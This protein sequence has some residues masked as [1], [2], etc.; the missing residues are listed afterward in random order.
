MPLPGLHERYWE[1]AV[2]GKAKWGLSL[3]MPN[4]FDYEQGIS[5][6]EHKYPSLYGVSLPR[7]CR[8]LWA[9]ARDGDVC[10]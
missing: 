3:G 9:C 8:T 1:T 10:E 4:P 7:T 6:M 2:L 5:Y